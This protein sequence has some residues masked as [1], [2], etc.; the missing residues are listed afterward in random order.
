MLAIVVM[1]P[2]WALVQNA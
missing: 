2:R 1:W